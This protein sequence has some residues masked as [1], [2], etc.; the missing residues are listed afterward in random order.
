MSK[1]CQYCNAEFKNAY[2]LKKHLNDTETKCKPKTDVLDEVASEFSN[3]VAVEAPST[4]LD[5]EAC[6]SKNFKCIVCNV[7]YIGVTN[8]VTHIRHILY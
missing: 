1:I 2:F 6:E 8:Y 5:V 4:T 3:I 7:K